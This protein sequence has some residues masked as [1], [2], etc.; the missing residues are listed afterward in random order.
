MKS[1]LGILVTVSVAFGVFSAASGASYEAAR[2]GRFGGYAS[3][4]ARP[5][6]G[7]MRRIHAVVKPVSILFFL[8]GL[9]AFV[10]GLRVTRRKVAIAGI[11]VCALMAAWSALLGPA[12]SFDEVYPAW[13]LATV[14][15][16]AVQVAVF[17][18]LAPSEGRPRGTD[19]GAMA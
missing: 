18:P 10:K 8:G 12:V 2:R 16:I 7:K 17:R 19:Q 14:V 1:L 11:L 15:L 13:I 3:L 9:S 5:D 6:Q 4:D